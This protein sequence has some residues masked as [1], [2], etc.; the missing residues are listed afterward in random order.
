MSFNEI[1]YKIVFYSVNFMKN[2]VFIYMTH[3]MNT[4]WNRQLVWRVWKTVPD[5]GCSR[6]GEPCPYHQAERICIQWIGGWWHSDSDSEPACEELSLAKNGWIWRSRKS[7]IAKESVWLTLCVGHGRP[8]VLLW[9]LAFSFC[10]YISGLWSPSFRTLQSAIFP[11]I[12]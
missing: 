4:N 10:M 3:F 11:Q 1:L 9:Y 8:L 2:Y 6:L 12:H 7:D 5:V